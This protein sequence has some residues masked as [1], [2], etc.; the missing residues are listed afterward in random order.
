[1]AH[2]RDVTQAVPLVAHQVSNLVFTN[3]IELP[4]NQVTYSFAALLGTLHFRDQFNPC[5]EID[6]GILR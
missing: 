4:V 6:T 2:F 1:M 3:D 5:E